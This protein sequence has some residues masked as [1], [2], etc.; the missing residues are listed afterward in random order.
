ME[1]I[2]QPNSKPKTKPIERITI[3]DTLKEQLSKLTAQAN[4]ALQGVASISKTDIVNFVLRQR[5]DTFSKAELKELRALHFDEIKFSQWMTLQLR[6]AQSTGE[7]ITIKELLERNIS[8]LEPSPKPAS[9]RP[10]GK[11]P[12]DES[13][14]VHQGGDYVI[15]P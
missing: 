14:P 2:E 10:R 15:E 4:D 11:L 6:K 8:M 5:S 3:D 12:A 9:K 7:A 1:K 13:Q